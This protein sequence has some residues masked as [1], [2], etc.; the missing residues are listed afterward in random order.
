MI[1]LIEYT[2][3]SKPTGRLCRLPTPRSELPDLL[4]LYGIT[5]TLDNGQL[6]GYHPERWCFVY[7][8]AMT[9]NPGVQ[10]ELTE[11]LSSE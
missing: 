11:L 7:Q 9:G 4:P 10:I 3:D 1:T 2:A 5:A 8:S 6:R